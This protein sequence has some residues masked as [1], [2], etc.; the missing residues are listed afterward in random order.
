LILPKYFFVNFV[1]AFAT[2]TI[3]IPALA[4]DVDGTGEVLK[5][6]PSYKLTP[7]YYH[8]SDGN[9]ATDL[10][11]RASI[12][13][14]TA[15]LGEYRDRAGFSQARAGYE[16]RQEADALRLVW[17]GQVAGGGFIGGSI[18]AEVGGANYG[19]VG[20]GRTNLRDYYNLNFDP[21]DAVT[22]GIGSRALPNYEVSLFQ[23]RDDR[24]ATEQ[25][26]THCVVRYKSSEFERWTVDTSYKTGLIDKNVFIRGYA[27]SITYDYRSIFIRLGRDQFANFT[28][29]SLTRISLGTRF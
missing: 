7:S 19:I 3:N 25:R 20:W 14:H 5:S 13:A 26:V 1:V 4:E 18:A 8:S 22:I 23:V 9:N 15:W 24:L 2:M 27:L 17:S 6:E 21:N 11:L 12:G 29:N 28:A 16:F 10:N